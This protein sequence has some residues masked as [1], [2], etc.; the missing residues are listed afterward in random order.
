MLNNRQI[1]PMCSYFAIMHKDIPRRNVLDNTFLSSNKT[2]RESQEGLSRRISH[3]SLTKLPKEE[4]KRISCFE[5]LFQAKM[6]SFLFVNV[7]NRK[8]WIV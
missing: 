1:K 8:I 7:P 6:H 2:M 3:L 5:K 4:N